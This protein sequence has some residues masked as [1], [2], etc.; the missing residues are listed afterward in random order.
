MK[1]TWRFIK[2]FVSN[3][4]WFEVLLFTSAFTLS[5]GFT[6]GEGTTLNIFWGITLGVNAIAMLVFLWWGMKR[7]WTDFKKHDEEMFNILK[8]K[9]IK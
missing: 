6:A 7:I 2:W 9:D 8:E 1:R 3:C 5:A 4:G